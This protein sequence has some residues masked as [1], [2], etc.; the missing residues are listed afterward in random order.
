MNFVYFVRLSNKKTYLIKN[1][2]G[3]VICQIVCFVSIGDLC[4]GAKSSELKA[5]GFDVINMSVGSPT[6]P[7]P[8]I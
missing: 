7:L 2:D 5:Q 3:F 8:N 4:D 1:Y 6:S